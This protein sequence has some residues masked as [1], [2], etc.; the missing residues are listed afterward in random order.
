M[1][2]SVRVHLTLW[3]TAVL[4]LVLVALALAGYFIFWQDTVQRTDSDLAELSSAFLTTLRAELG[5]QSGSAA[6]QSAAQVAITEHR[7]R[8][9][10]FA[11]LDPSGKLFITSF[12]LPSAKSVPE[13]VPAGLLSS[14][15]FRRF[16]EA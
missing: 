8:D 1:F 3:Y 9:H 2:E 13:I 16:A 7:F 5:D 14:A 10:V 11:L 4:A 12:D 6:L 15:S